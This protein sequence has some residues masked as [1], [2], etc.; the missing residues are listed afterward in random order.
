[1]KLKLKRVAQTERGTFGVL[2][3]DKNI[4]LCVTLEDPWK[5]NLKNISSIPEG[6]Y[7]VSPHNGTKFKNVWILHDVP[8]RSA[9]L[10]HA[11]NSTND[12]SGC[13]LV[14]RSFNGHMITQSKDALDFLRAILPQNFTLEIENPISWKVEIPTKMT[15]L[16]WADII[17]EILKKGFK[18]WNK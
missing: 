13:V 4:P 11:G 8:H 12:T 14:G 2:L 15:T 10:I 5:D 1:M 9:I 16:S 6:T 18:K 17:K 7:K 3:N